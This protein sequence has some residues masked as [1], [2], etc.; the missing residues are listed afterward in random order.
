MSIGL[1]VRLLESMFVPT[2]LYECGV[3]FWNESVRRRL[4][5]IEMKALRMICGVRRRD[6]VRNERVREM[7][8]WRR[9]LVER[10]QQGI[11]KWFGHVI[12]MVGIGW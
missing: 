2:G 6:R 11:L 8:G 4:E 7:C 12:R 3:W 10:C 9:G 1:K 5:V